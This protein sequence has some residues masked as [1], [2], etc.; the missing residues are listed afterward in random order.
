M[1]EKVYTTFQ[2]ADI[3]S[4]RASTVIKWVQ[5]QRLRAYQTPGGHRRIK[6]SDL[7]EFLGKYNLPVPENFTP[8]KKR[9]LIVDDEPA[10]ALV[11]RRALEKSFDSVEVSWVKDGVEALI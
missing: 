4:V 6:H 2:V 9:V 11:L 3:C 10:V 1:K 8:Y 5:N 7:V